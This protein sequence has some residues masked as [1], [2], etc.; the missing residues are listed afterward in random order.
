MR[1]HI[2]P[3]D[4]KSVLSAVEMLEQYQR[5]EPERR[6]E[7]LRRIAEVGR[8]AAQHAVDAAWVTYVHPANAKKPEI[9]VD[10]SRIKEGHVEIH[11]KG[12]N[13]GFLE[14]GTSE[15]RPAYRPKENDYVP[16]PR[17]SYGKGGGKSKPNGEPASWVIP[18]SGGKI[19]F[20][21]APAYAMDAAMIAMIQQRDQI[22]KEVY[23][24]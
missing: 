12:H 18:Y 24:K 5:K 4:K 6:E 8:V 15:D 22:V 16:D 19:S 13:A 10:F 20:G 23:G 3:T 7:I 17:G 1:I 11:M 2:D 14:F 21:N 9:V